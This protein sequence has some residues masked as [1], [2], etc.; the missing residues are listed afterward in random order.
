MSYS[1]SNGSGGGGGGGSY[2]YSPPPSPPSYSPPS[3]SGAMSTGGFEDNRATPSPPPSPGWVYKNN[4]HEDAAVA[5]GGFEDNRENGGGGGTE[6]II[7]TNTGKTSSSSSSSDTSI[8]IGASGGHRHKNKHHHSRPHTSN[9]NSTEEDCNCNGFWVCVGLVLT[10]VGV[11][12]LLM[13]GAALDPEPKA[14]S[15]PPVPRVPTF[16]TKKPASKSSF[17]VGT[18]EAFESSFSPASISKNTSS[19][20]FMIA[21]S[22]DHISIEHNSKSAIFTFKSRPKG[23]TNYKRIFKFRDGEP[24][25]FT[26]LDDHQETVNVRVTIE[27][28]NGSKVWIEKRE[29]KPKKVRIERMF[30]DTGMAVYYTVDKVIYVKKF[31]RR[32]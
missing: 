32:S 13:I 11:I 19:R 18:F 25:F 15:K 3:Y 31:K 1:G 26:K 20:A 8:K 12:I 7:M 5:L 22:E 24:F 29:E 17:Y 6:V 16:P 4:D 27:V 28:N 2:S 30:T 23:S 10:V 9:V 21:Q 14:A